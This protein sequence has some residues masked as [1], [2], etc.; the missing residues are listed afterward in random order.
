M[1]ESL[2]LTGF[3]REHKTL[4]VLV[5]VGLLLVEIEIF[6]LAAMKSGRQSR[7]EVYNQQGHLIYETD[8]R[9]L[10]QF[11]RSHF[12]KTF[13]PLDQYEVRMTRSERPFPFRAWLTAAV[14]VPVGTVLLLAFVVRACQGLFSGDRRPASVSGADGPAVPDNRL[15][16]IFAQLSRLNIFALGTIVLVTVLGYW[17]VPNLIV[18]LGQ[19]GLDTLL[20]FKWFFLAVAVAGFG[21]VVWIV[22]LRY[23]LAKKSIES[24]AQVE[25]FRL[26]LESDRRTDTPKLLECSHGTERR[27]EVHSPEQES[28]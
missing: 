27:P 15:L 5:T 17:V 23:L 16:R 3:F 19:V 6:A 14:G 28:P 21:L 13:G 2:P 25:K 24:N 4:L 1:S 18:Y 20:R 7:L 11:S 26:Q 12:E 22:Y 10:S 9:S 8:G